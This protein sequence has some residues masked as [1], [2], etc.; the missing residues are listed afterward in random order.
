MGEAFI[1]KQMEVSSYGSCFVYF[2]G[3]YGGGIVVL[4][5]FCLL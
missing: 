1:S 5:L 3:F 4:F 2:M